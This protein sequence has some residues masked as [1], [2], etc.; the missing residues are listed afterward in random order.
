VG[1]E[2]GRL[3]LHAETKLPG[4]AC[5]EFRLDSSGDA[6]STKLTMTARFRSKGL[7][8]ILYWH[9]VVPLHSIVFGSMLKGITEYNLDLVQPR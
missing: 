2:R 9:S 4:T 5:L 6:S 7:F 3:L 8:G 1:I